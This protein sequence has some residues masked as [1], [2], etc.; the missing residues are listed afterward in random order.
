MF[1][2]SEDQ[3]DKAYPLPLPRGGGKSN[4]RGIVV[5]SRRIFFL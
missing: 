3:T 1:S 5:M 2:R 4:R